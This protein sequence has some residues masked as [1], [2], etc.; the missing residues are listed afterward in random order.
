MAVIDHVFPDS[1]TNTFATLNVLDA[2]SATLSNGNLAA[3]INAGPNNSTTIIPSSGTWYWEVYITDHT[4]I[5]MGIV[6]VNVR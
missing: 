4:N 2:E 3:T 1:P 5:Y 6:F